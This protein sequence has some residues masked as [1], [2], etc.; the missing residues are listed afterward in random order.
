MKD[1]LCAEGHSVVSF[2]FSINEKHRRNPAVESRLS[3][4]LR[5]EAPD[6]VF[7]FNF[8][9]EISNVCQAESIRYVSWVYDS[10]A[11]MLYSCA[12]INS[13]NTV[14]VFDKEVYLEFHRGGVGTVRYLPMAAG[15]K[16]AGEATPPY[17][18]DISF[19][20]SLYT[21][22]WNFFDQMTG[23][24]EYA[25]GYLDAVISAQLKVQG[26]NFVQEIL[27]PVMEELQKAFP[28]SR[29]ED[30]IETM[31]WFYAQYVV[32]RKITSLERRDLLASAA[33]RHPL[34]LFTVDP[35]VAIPGVRNH[36]GV[37]Y[38]SGMPQVFRQSRI[39]LNI[40]LR[41]IQS[42]IPLRA[43]DIMG[44]GGFLMTNF[45]ADF[46]DFFVPGEDYVFYD[47]KEDL[48]G[49][50]DYYLEH[51]EERRRIARNGWNKVI[52]G[53]TFRHRIREMFNF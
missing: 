3:S 48:L 27:S 17:L 14:Y 10:P 15:V 36:G 30:G 19:V 18:Y 42:G 24:S 9:P 43:F 52:R 35:D 6:A 21:E 33:L 1:A 22:R 23:L 16:D 2:P 45:Q 25:R 7:S 12:V 4:A 38:D 34:D 20:G 41:S 49:K 26:Y 31:E 51:E 29:N 47:S 50:I 46:L 28:M 39:N 32:N 44:S 11:I 37:D 5:H 40:S 53:H 8:F 13:C